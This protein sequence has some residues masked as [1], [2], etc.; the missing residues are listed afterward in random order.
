LRN[1]FATRRPKL[2][3]A[4]F[5]AAVL[6]AVAALQVADLWWRRDRMLAA[7]EQRAR[8]LAFLLSEYVR[9]SFAATDTAL[10]QL[11]LHGRRFGGSSAGAAEWDAMLA[12]AK[13]ALPE[14]GSLTM[15]DADGTIRS[16]T[17]R[18][19][20]G[21]SRREEYV[22][23][24]LSRLDRDE[25]VVSTPFASVTPPKRFLIPLG[26]RLVTAEGRFD[27]TVVATVLPEHYR[28]FFRTVDAGNDAVIWVFHPS[29]LVLFREPSAS[30]PIGETAVENPVLRAAWQGDGD[31]VVTAPLRAD[32]PPYISSYRTIAAPPLIVAVSLNRHAV[33]ADWR[34][35]RRTSVIAFGVLTAT[36]LVLTL[37]LFRQIDARVRAEQE[38]KDR[39]HAAL[40][41]EQRARRDIERASTL[42]DEFLMMVS[43]ELRTPL[44][45]IYGWVRMLEKDRLP[46]DQRARALDA[47]DRNAR[48]QTRLIDD[49]LDVSRAST[50]KIRLD[51][52]ECNI[53]GVV[54]A[55]ADTLRPAIDAKGIRFEPSI[56]AG[57]EPV[58]V[59]PDRLQQ[60]VWNLLSN[61][62]KFTPD[63]GTV[64]LRVA[65]VGAN[66][67]IVVSDT[68]LGI[69]PE[70][71]PHLFERFR[72]AETGSRRRFAGL[73]LGLAI[74]RH[75]VELHGGT[76]QAASAGT[77][78]GATFRVL[79][80][81]RAMRSAAPPRAEPTARAAPRAP[82]AAVPRL[83]GF[84]VL[85]VDDDSDTLD[86]FRSILTAAG[87]TALTAAS[88][89]EALRILEDTHVDVLVS[90]IEMPGE[91]GYQLVARAR[92]VRRTLIAVAVTGYARIV[93]R[94]RAL[95]AGFQAHLAKPVDPAELVAVIADSLVAD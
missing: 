24:E 61:A 38:A 32:G 81:S 39:L 5:T 30:D 54:Y 16:S 41:R 52:R 57:L 75:L 70:F 21:Q 23:Q 62:I 36:L 14:I 86:L 10:A 71:L 33:L 78:Q 4:A 15:A 88:A 90:D 11:A 58:V 31:G 79:L 6:V 93:D 17:V 69:D 89:A 26:R 64:R 27:G 22:H 48:A 91:D 20:V 85:V 3:I 37:F 67:E 19:I 80:P 87:A 72:Q 25:L 47:I 28:A 65:A 60:I 95:E 53:A 49:L 83:D 12:A 50:G 84:R 9:G 29:G 55:A 7:A 8:S 92:E 82:E 2:V 34:D 44:T 43:H 74:T 94:R 51:A 42:K 68:G 76:I 13:A 63:G 18:A 59:D 73:G 56:E 40:E 77:G 1:P 66:V 45:A 35:Q 46:P